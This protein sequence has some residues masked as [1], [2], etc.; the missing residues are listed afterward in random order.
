MSGLRSKSFYSI[1]CRCTVIVN[2]SFR[3]MCQLGKCTW[4]YSLQPYDDIHN[5]SVIFEF[6]RECLVG[7]G[8]RVKHHT[9]TRN[10]WPASV[11]RTLVRCKKYRH[12]PQARIAFA[13]LQYY[14]DLL[15]PAAVLYA[16][17]KRGNVCFPTNLDSKSW[18]FYPHYCCILL[19]TPV[20]RLCC[21]SAVLFFQAI[22]SRQSRFE[23]WLLLEPRL[24]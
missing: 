5:I 2:T 12:H 22:I 23:L 11:N 21:Q 14:G 16:G 18:L 7:C 13:L 17:M 1:A 3:P 9:L 15:N 8:K 19:I 24:S 6:L 10:C 4:Y 20:L